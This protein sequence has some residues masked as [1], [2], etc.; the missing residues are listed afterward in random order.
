M[1][2]KKVIH[3]AF[4]QVIESSKDIAKSSVKQVTETLSPWDMIRNSFSDK[5]MSNSNSRLN[6]NEI[7]KKGQ[8]HTPLDFENLDQ[9]Y[10]NQDKQRLDSMKQR[11]FQMVQRDDERSLQQSK[12]TKSEKER[13]LAYEDAENKRREEARKRHLIQGDAPEGKSG[14]GTA[15]MGKK[16][17]KHAAEPQPAETKPG[18]GKF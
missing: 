1:T 16:K 17:K 7:Q 12:H 18:G 3:N 8:K 15:L 5:E 10:A 2:F 9:K 4:E 13:A 11:L 14:R 6:S